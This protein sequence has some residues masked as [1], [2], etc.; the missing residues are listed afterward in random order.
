MTSRDILQ[1]RLINQQLAGS[2]FKHAPELVSYMGCIQAQDFAGAKWAIGKRIKGITDALVEKCFS[3]GKILRTHVLRPTW[4]FVSPDDIGWML[5]LSAPR[6]KAMSKGMHSKVGI[7]DKIL[8]QSKKIITAALM[9][10]NQLSREELLPLFINKGVNIDTFK[11]GF[12]LMDAEL[13]GIICSGPRKGKQ[14]TYALLEERVQ[15]HRHLDKDEALAELAKRYF[16]SRGPA[17]VQDFAWW[18]GLNL[19]DAKIGLDIIKAQLAH[20][21]INGHTH[22]FS[23]DIQNSKEALNSIY[24]LPPF[25]EYAVSYKDRSYSLD[26]QY[27]ILTG[28]GIFKPTLIINGKISGTWKRAERKDKVVIETT[29]FGP[30]DEQSLKKI[31]KEAK[32]Y[33]L[34]LGKTGIIQ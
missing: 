16:T 14:F 26:P 23:S 4:H 20:E 2:A 13:D 22:W 30:L 25:D 10:S 7:D 19:T 6:L 3:E 15:K 33:A 1:Q 17:T 24:L 21:I 18:G 32:R 27:N 11:L 29:P 12:L 9:D 34:F 8:I 5:R 31:H 28:N